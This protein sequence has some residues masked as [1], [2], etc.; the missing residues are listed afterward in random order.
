[1]S[2]VVYWRKV[3]VAD[4]LA[5][6]RQDYV[7]EPNH[8]DRY[9]CPDN[10]DVLV[11]DEVVKQWFKM[12]TEQFQIAKRKLPEPQLAVSGVFVPD[13]PMKTKFWPGDREKKPDVHP[14]CTYCGELYKHCG[15]QIPEPPK[16]KPITDF[17]FDE[18]DFKL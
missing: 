18:E 14:R 1:M 16:P 4:Y 7:I 13:I 11:Y 5:D 17:D 6:G 3:T 12:T 9:V 10:M 8:G 2:C 15:C